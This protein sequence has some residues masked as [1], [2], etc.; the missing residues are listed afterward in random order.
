MFSTD[1]PDQNVCDYAVAK[2]RISPETSDLKHD[3]TGRKFGRLFVLSYSHID[4]WRMPHWVC[5]CVCGKIVDTPVTKSLMNGVTLSCGCYLREITTNRLRTH[6]QTGSSLFNR[7]Q[8]MKRRC[9][10]PRN[11]DYRRYGGRGITVCE[12]WRDSF[13][14]FRDWALSNGYR[15]DLTIDR[16]DNDSDYTPSNCQWITRLDNTRKK[17]IVRITHCKR[18]HEFT[19]NNT[20][21]Q[22]GGRGNVIRRCKSCS[23]ER[24]RKYRRLTSFS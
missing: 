22:S 21:L 24:T 13:E 2:H 9:G 7:W 15:H 23:R 20:N 18:G 11:K 3:L 8:S 5:A 6:G 19:P 12:E 1:A 17:P 10:S 14:T 4:K 16:I